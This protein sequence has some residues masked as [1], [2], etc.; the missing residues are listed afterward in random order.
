MLSFIL[1]PIE[2]WHL[3]WRILSTSTNFFPKFW[4][5]S[6][7]KVMCQEPSCTWSRSVLTVIKNRSWQEYTNIIKGL[8]SWFVYS[9]C[10]WDDTRELLLLSLQTFLS[11]LSLEQPTAT[12][13]PHNPIFFSRCSLKVGWCDEAILHISIHSQDFL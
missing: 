4:D 1:L 10:I 5:L 2:K 6:K 8:T 7:F 12:P 3:Y 11:N 9:H 13:S